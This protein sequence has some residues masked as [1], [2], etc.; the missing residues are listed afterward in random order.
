SLDQLYTPE[1]TETLNI[2]REQIKIAREGEEP[3][4]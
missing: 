4:S 3:G 1:A 2:L